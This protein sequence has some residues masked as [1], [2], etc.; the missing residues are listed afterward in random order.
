MPA[1]S[2]LASIAR[3]AFVPVLFLAS[4]AR[5]DGVPREECFPV[6]R[7]SPAARAKAEELLLRMLDREALYTLV[8]GVK[9]VSGSFWSTQFA[10]ESPDLTK[11]DEARE[12]LSAV[13]CGDA[14]EAGILVFDATTG[15]NR[16]AHAW[17]AHRPSVKRMLAEHQ[18]FFGRYGLSPSTPPTELVEKMEHAPRADRLRA[19]GHFYG[20]PDHAVDFFIDAE[21]RRESSGDKKTV[22]RDFISVPTFA[23]ATGHFVWAVPKG[24]QANDADRALM[25]KSDPI[26]AEYRLRRAFYIGE[27]KPGVV[28]LLRDWF[29]DGY[30]RCAPENARFDGASYVPWPVAAPLAGAAPQPQ[31]PE[32]VAYEYLWPQAV[33]PAYGPPKGLFLRRLPG[34]RTAR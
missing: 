28:A 27:G 5:G 6:E 25:A 20:Y 32:P 24:H 1:P 4:A 22:E 12:A 2:R 33:P 34:L 16:A 31:A 13:R 9:P 29:D 18:G 11:L 3:L 8:G 17:V 23:A 10:L 14:Y 15:K 19:S 7:L 30:G 21:N 26:L